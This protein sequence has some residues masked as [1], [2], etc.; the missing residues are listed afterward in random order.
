MRAITAASQEVQRVL[1]QGP[2]LQRSFERLEQFQHSPDTA[3]LLREAFGNERPWTVERRTAE[4]GKTAYRLQLEAGR[5]LTPEGE[6]REWSAFP[7]DFSLDRGGQS[8]SYRGTWPSLSFDDKDVRVTV[9]DGYLSGD[10]RRGAGNLWYGNM[11]AGFGSMQFD[12][13]DKPITLLMRDL[14]VT[15]RVQ[16]RPRTLDLNYGFGIKSI[17]AVGERIDDLK[18]GLRLVN[19]E[20]STLTAMRAAQAKMRASETASRDFSAL[21]PMLKTMAR[22]A[23]KSKTAVVVDDVSFG[24]HGYRASMQ[25]R[26]GLGNLTD[27][28]F[29]DLSRLSK[30]VNARFKVQVP[31]A[32]VREL[33]LSIARHEAAKKPGQDPEKVAKDV[34]DVLLGK[35]L[36]NGFARLEN[37]VLVSTIE[38]RD[39]ILRINGKKIDLP[40]PSKGP[41][42]NTA[43]NY[44]QAR[45][46]VDSCTLPDYPREIVEKDAGFVLVLKY[47]VDADGTLRGLQSIKPSEYP[48]YDAAVLEAFQACRFQPALQDGKPVV[49][50]AI[51]TLMREPGSVRP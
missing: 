10:Q 41:A 13:K 49:Q 44:M 5:H 16:E 15:T 48:D 40:K 19:I 37:E 38:V 27:A 14:W 9:R 20:K 43:A 17:E 7:I 35:L 50:T 18:F 24:F 2:S 12:G 39:D 33:A 28:D 3:K 22:G 11:Q 21:L 51:D 29:A 45:R 42:P 25:G 6:A 23:A 30:R 26:V 8:A 32:M 4:A 31:L 1:D 34:T 46:I 47:T 36:S